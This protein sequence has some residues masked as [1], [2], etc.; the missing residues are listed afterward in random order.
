MEKHA[1]FGLTLVA[2]ATCI[3]FGMPWWMSLVT[4]MASAVAYAWACQ[5]YQA[6]LDAIEKAA[7]QWLD[8]S[9]NRPLVRGVEHTRRACAEIRSTLSALEHSIRG[10]NSE[11][12]GSFSGLG[13]KTS[14]I[15][16]QISEVLT[17]VTGASDT[18]ADSNDAVVTV[19]TF[20]GEVSDILAQYVEL[21]I[22]VSEKSVQAVHH[23]G[24]MV[25]ELEHMFSLL[26][27][28]RTIAEQTNL[29]AL[30]AAI[31]AA[32]AGEAG[33][34]F[35]V[36]ADEV[37]KLSQSTNTLSDQIRHRAETAKSTI[38]E[39]KDIVGAIASLDL[40]NAINAK[41]R[42]DGMLK[43]LEEMN[44]TISDTMSRL[45]RLNEG[46][47]Q[48]TNR[49]VRALQFEDFSSQVIGEINRSVANLEGL[50]N[51]VGRIS[52]EC[53]LPVTLEADVTRVEQHLESVGDATIRRR[54][55]ASGDNIDLF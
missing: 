32:R 11:L 19:E 36:V 22:D 16:R 15:N 12:A 10:A 26:N 50:G 46:I 42:V 39:V 1:V 49:A 5:G 53:K 8:G 47:N 35:A 31:E 14:Q 18:S 34:G 41:G 9:A 29:L 38:T 25:Q 44:H 4:L 51:L 48:D 52:A 7:P 2:T 20:A 54:E 3:A 23:I 17:V 30:N 13:E 24:D 21:L 43:G 40:N 33:R 55:Q 45:T 6:R 27:Q 37:R 28:I